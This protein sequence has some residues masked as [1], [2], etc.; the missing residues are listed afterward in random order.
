MQHWNI[1]VQAVL[2][3][4]KHFYLHYVS[5]KCKIFFRNDLPGLVWSCWTILNF[6]LYYTPLYTSGLIYTK[7]HTQIKIS[8]F[9]KISFSNYGFYGYLFYRQSLGSFLSN[10]NNYWFCNVCGG[11]TVTEAA[12]ATSKVYLLCPHFLGPLHPVCFWCLCCFKADIRTP[13]LWL[14]TIGLWCNKGRF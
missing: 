12:V 10:L 3:Y 4:L 8:P 1:V 7:I 14:K 2:I 5:T 9:L 11:A 13:T 6:W